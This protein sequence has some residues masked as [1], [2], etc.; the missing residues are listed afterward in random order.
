VLGTRYTIMAD[1]LIVS[2]LIVG[3]DH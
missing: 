1:F 3:A 2:A